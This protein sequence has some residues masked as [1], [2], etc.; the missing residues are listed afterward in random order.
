[1]IVL[2][3]AH[4]AASGAGVSGEV[5]LSDGAVTIWDSRE[6]AGGR[7]TG[8]K[9]T[10][11]GGSRH[12]PDGGGQPLAGRRRPGYFRPSRSHLDEAP[13]DAYPLRHR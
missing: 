2:I 6:R 10:P 9:V 5:W 12:R 8:T 1:L 7:G 3:E 13:P 4:A 11:G